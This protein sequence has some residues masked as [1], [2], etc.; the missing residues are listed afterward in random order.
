MKKVGSN[1]LDK[2]KFE[3]ECGIGVVVSKAQI[4]K[5]VSEAIDKVKANLLKERYN[6][7]LTNL[8]ASL[9]QNLKGVDG[10]ELK[11]EVDNQIKKLL[12]ER[13]EQD[14]QKPVKKV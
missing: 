12:G 9:R 14:N 4:E 11:D 10:K 7:S 13:T 8:L 1:S 6:Y 3:E 5:T 2:G